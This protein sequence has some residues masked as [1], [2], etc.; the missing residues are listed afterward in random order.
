[1]RQASGFGSHL[2]GVGLEVARCS[3]KVA[4]ASRR[5]N[6]QPI[7]FCPKTKIMAR[8]AINAFDAIDVRLERAG[9]CGIECLH[10]VKQSRPG[11]PRP[12]NPSLCY[13][14]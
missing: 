13:I 14:S 9:A 1:M 3:R 12:E 5:P 7:G 6:S 11:M 10:G 2:V 8:Y 4:W